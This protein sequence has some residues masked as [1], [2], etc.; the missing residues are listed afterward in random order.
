M[1]KA[2]TVKR[3]TGH[4]LYIRFV[5]VTLGCAATIAAC[6]SSKQSSPAAGSSRYGQGLRFSECMRSHGVPSFPDPSAGGGIHIPAGSGISPFSPSF[7]AAQSV[8]SKLLPGGGPGN[9]HATAKQIE[10]TRQIS[11]CMR[12]HGVTGFPDPTFTPPSS[13]AGYSIIEDRGGVILAVPSTINPQSPVF[14]Q[15]AKT[16][17]FS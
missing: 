7:K 2:T 14:V 6:G 8:C 9:Q 10:M 1:L 17:H 12:Q 15:A 16:C 5:L 11:E 4:S 13:P 3:P